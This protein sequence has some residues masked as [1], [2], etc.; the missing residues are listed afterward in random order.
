MTIVSLAMV[1]PERESPVKAVKDTNP[2][3]PPKWVFRPPNARRKL[4]R[5]ATPHPGKASGNTKRD[6]LA[7]LTETGRV[8]KKIVFELEESAAG[9]NGGN[10]PA[11]VGKVSSPTGDRKGGRWNRKA[12]P[13][14]FEAL[15]LSMGLN[16]VEPGVLPLLAKDLRFSM[17]KRETS[18]KEQP[19][20]AAGTGQT[21][22]AGA[23]PE[24]DRPVENSAVSLDG[25]RPIHVVVDA[26][27]ATMDEDKLQIGDGANMLSEST[28]IVAPFPE[29]LSHVLASETCDLSHIKSSHE[30][31]FAVDISFLAEKATVG[32]DGDPDGKSPAPE[33]SQ[34]N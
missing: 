12:R 13:G 1:Q 29:M 21:S 28:N 15:H 18:T 32:G 23:R 5:T 22:V 19:E 2:S 11:G 17:G 34:E 6:A 4:K 33:T 14:P 16:E 3:P 9:I 25:A 31:E 24:V 10:S 7:S 30:F 27:I 8:R 20:V 26:S